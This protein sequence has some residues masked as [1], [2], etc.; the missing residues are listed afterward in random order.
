[1][2]KIESRNKSGYIEPNHDDVYRFIR[3][4]LGEHKQRRIRTFI[5]D[6]CM[7]VVLALLEEAHEQGKGIFD[8]PVFKV[9]EQTTMKA[10]FT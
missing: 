9:T 7:N 10:F 5:D 1:M 4:V 3:E 2:P 6:R 8:T